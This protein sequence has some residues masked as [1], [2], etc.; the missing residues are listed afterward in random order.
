VSLDL[1][2][3]FNRS[4]VTTFN[5]TLSGTGAAWL[6]P[7]SILAARLAKLSVQFDW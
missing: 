4:A 7:T 1:F 6:Q 3:V 2:N 5:Q